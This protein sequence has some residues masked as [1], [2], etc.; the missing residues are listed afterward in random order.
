MIDT[1][2]LLSSSLVT[3]PPRGTLDTGCARCS[4]R[5]MPASTPNG[6]DGHTTAEPDA[7]TRT[8]LSLAS[9]RS[10][11]SPCSREARGK[12]G[13]TDDEL[14]CAHRVEADGALDARA[15]RSAGVGLQTLRVQLHGRRR[16]GGCA[17]GGRGLAGLGQGLHRAE[18]DRSAFAAEQLPSIPARASE[19]QRSAL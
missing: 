9:R 8:A 11:R 19:H 3:Q 6:T 16:L 10:S 15:V 17:G 1:A 13:R 2:A 4:V 12:E 14:P 18:V 7:H 5:T